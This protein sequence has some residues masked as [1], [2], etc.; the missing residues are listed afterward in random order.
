[1]STRKRSAFTLVELLVVIAVIGIL[2]ALLLP[3]VQAAREA[4]R[5]TQCTNNLKQIALAT[6]DYENVH[7]ELPP[8]GLVGEEFIEFGGREYQVYKQRTGNMFSWVVL[9][10]PFLEE[11]N[12]FDQFDL[13]QHIFF[14]ANR[15]Q[16]EPLQVFMCPSDA[17]VPRSYHDTD[18]AG[19]IP[20]AKGNYAAYVSPF[21]GD[22]QMVYP[23]AIIAT[24]QKLSRITD[25][26]SKTVAFAEVRTLDHPLDER[27][28]WALPW[29]GATQLALDMHH[30]VEQSGGVYS[31]YWPQQQF[32]YQAQLP[33]SIGPNADVLIR[34]VPDALI[35]AQLQRM[36]C[37]RWDSPYGLNGYISAAPRSTHT[38]GVFAAYLDGHVEFIYDDIDPYTMAFLVDI[39]DSEVGRPKAG[40]EEPPADH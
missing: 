9:I 11:Q 30:D 15:P 39:R 27:G 10:L 6:L 14:Q 25:G 31:E 20:Y 19:P 2:I 35:D 5:R 24:G 29:N 37:K 26:A 38:G 21:H 1:V 12:L 34:C 28:A 8:S 18:Y 33:N 23:G 13:T 7:G 17:G 40:S 32:A 4:A 36:P 16:S 3:A 22:I